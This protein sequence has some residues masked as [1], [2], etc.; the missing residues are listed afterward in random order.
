MRPLPPTITTFM[1][2]PS[3]AR[4]SRH[5]GHTASGR[6]GRLCCDTQLAPERTDDASELVGVALHVNAR[7]AFAIRFERLRGF[8]RTVDES[9]EAPLAV[10]DGYLVVHGLA[11]PQ[12]GGE[13]ELRDALAAHQRHA[14]AGH[15][16]P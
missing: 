15:L 6:L 9:Q 7:D 2:N 13:V 8:Q 12:G 11:V 10:E 1:L 14:E 5:H 16:A 3:S 4:R